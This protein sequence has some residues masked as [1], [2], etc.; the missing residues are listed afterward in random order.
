MKHTPLV[1]SLAPSLCLLRALYIRPMKRGGRLVLLSMACVAIAASIALVWPRQN[2]PVYQGKTLSQWLEKQQFQLQGPEGDA[3]RQMGSN[4]A[5]FLVK[6]IQYQTPAWRRQF[7]LFWLRQFGHILEDPR[8]LRRLN[9]WFAFEA[10][11]PQARTAVPELTRLLNSPKFSYLHDSIVQALGCLGDDA[12]PT[13]LAALKEQERRE[14]ATVAL[15]IARESF[16]TIRAKAVPVLVQCLSDRA[17]RTAECAAIALGRMHLEP[18]AVVPAL[19]HSLGDSRE[20]V[21]LAAI[22]S[23]GKFGEEARPAV[24]ALLPFLADSNPVIRQSAA[25]ALG[26]LAPEQLESSAIEK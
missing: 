11:G 3:V 9:S 16:G 12:F 2:E 7:S 25:T 13:L 5:P 22:M 24:P 21:R 4:A 23:L 26:K 1:L 15:V 17:G 18:T 20:T 6:W 8:N 14:R 10:L 19:I